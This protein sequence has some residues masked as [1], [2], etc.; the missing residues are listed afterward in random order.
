M[1]NPLASE[2]WDSQVTLDMI[3]LVIS[4]LVVQL[5]LLVEVEVSLNNCLSW[6]CAWFACTNALGK[7]LGKRNS[8]VKWDIPKH[9]TSKCV[10]TIS[11]NVM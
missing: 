1:Q 6:E 2:Q 10:A 5:Y 4:T 8:I 11:Y 9:F 7:C 3:K